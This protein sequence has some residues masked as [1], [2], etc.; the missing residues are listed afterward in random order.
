MKLVILD[1]YSV[2]SDDLSWHQ[3]Q[4]IVEVTSYDN[5]NVSQII[6]RCKG[7]Q[8]ALTN[9]VVFDETVISQLPDLK[10]IGVLATG[11]NVVDTE[12]ARRHGIVVTNIPAY[13]TDSVVQMVWAH[14][15]NIYNK[16]SY[17]ANQNRK[18]RWSA[19]SDFCYWDE[20]LHELS[21]KT[22]GIVGLGNIGIRVAKIAVAFGLKVLA[23]TSKSPDCL[24]DG[25][26][27][28]GMDD[29]LRKSDILSLHCPLTAENK[30]MI[31]RDSLSKIKPG[32]VLINTGRGGLVNEQD[33][34]DALVDGRLGA[35]GADVLTTEPP[36]YDNPLLTAPHCYL[37]PHIAWA[38]VEAR[39]R[40]INIC[41][42][43]IKAFLSGS[44]QNQVN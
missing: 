33:V 3:L 17:Y 21:G 30:E 40:L 12:S 14:I 36:T 38:T 13:S 27:R 4:D 6:E 32:A 37:T 42:E 31:N 34:A 11:Y 29:L 10:Y 7:H 25:I 16:V 19:C 23:V 44:P 18:G 5:T 2:T 22:F 15:L 9:K 41:T 26:D 35:Y 8:M 20:A 28:V 39:Q 1:S 43:N 24:P